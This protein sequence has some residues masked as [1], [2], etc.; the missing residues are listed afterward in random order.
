MLDLCDE[1]GLYVLDEAN[2]ES[3]A[4]LRSLALDPSYH[5]AIEQRTKRMLQRDRNHPS[6][7]GWSLGNE[8]GFGPAQI[9]AAAWV[10]S[11]DPSRFIHYEGGLEQRFSLNGPNGFENSRQPP[12]DEERLTTD[13]VCPMYSPLKVI[14]EWAEWADQTKQDE[15]PLILCEFSHSM[16]NSNGSLTEYVLSL[17]HI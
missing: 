6:V 3:H 7:I 17:I 16:G 4:R 13:I 2:C 12:N 11:E 10:R 5:H 1:I 14:S 9:A 8:S 15:R